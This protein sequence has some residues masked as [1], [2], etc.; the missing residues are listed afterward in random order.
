MSNITLGMY[1]LTKNLTTQNYRCQKGDIKQVPHLEP[2]SIRCHS[3]KFSCHGHLGF[4]HLR[5]KEP[6]SADHK[7]SEQVILT[8]KLFLYSVI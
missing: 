6:Q 8:D 3:T 7:A 4:V 1:K 2:T 5:N